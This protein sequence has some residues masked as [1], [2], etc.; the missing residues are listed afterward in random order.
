MTALS[1]RIACVPPTVTHHHKKIITIKTRDGRQFNKLGDKPEL[2]HARAMLEE[3][4]LPHQ[5]S[6]P[7]TGPVALSLEFTWPWLA[8]HS[9]RMRMLHRIPMTSR[10]DG[11][12]CAKTLED[13]LTALRFIEDDNAVVDLRVTKWWGDTPGIAITIAPFVDGVVLPSSP[14]AVGD[15]FAVAPLE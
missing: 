2:Q 9:K 13:R 15:L 11:S 5:P 12:N 8:K 1:F 6:T 7:I 14:R 10:P 3:L 4:L